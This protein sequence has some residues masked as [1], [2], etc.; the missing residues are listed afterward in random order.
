MDHQRAQGISW[1]LPEDC[2][3][4]SPSLNVLS[5][6]SNSSSSSTSS[7]VNPLPPI[8]NSDLESPLGKHKRR[9]R[10]RYDVISS[11]GDSLKKME[12]VVDVID[13]EDEDH[14][15]TSFFVEME[16][17]S[18]MPACVKRPMVL[19]VTNT[20]TVTASYWIELFHVRSTWVLFL[21]DV[22]CQVTRFKLLQVI[23][24][25]DSVPGTSFVGVRH[26]SPLFSPFWVSSCRAF[27][28]ARE[29]S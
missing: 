21:K 25:K 8:C 4:I 26:A 15:F 22:L 3:P 16:V 2:C 17:N 12:E 5:S 29:L 20:E 24:I 7:S 13:I 11:R 10:I 9:R 23:H 28:C 19:F 27:Q 18:E 14:S 6:S 1:F